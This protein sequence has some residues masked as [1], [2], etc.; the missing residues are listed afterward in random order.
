MEKKPEESN[1]VF[2]PQENETAGPEKA[3][4]GN[5]PEEG[6]AAAVEIKTAEKTP[7]TDA[8]KTIITQ[9]KEDKKTTEKPADEKPEGKTAAK[10]KKKK[11]KGKNSGPMKIVIL[12]MVIGLLALGAYRIIASLTEKEEIEADPP[13]NVYVD[14]VDYGNVEITTPLSGRIEPNEEVSLIP[15]I[16]GEVE[17]LNVEVGDYVRKGDVLFRI[18]PMQLETAYDQAVASYDLAQSS[19]DAAKT[20]YDRMKMLYEE[21]VVARAEFEAAE[22]Q[23]ESALLSLAQV[24]VSVNS[25]EESLK[26]AT[27]LAPMNGYVTAVNIVEGAL[28]TQATPAVTIA[29]TTKLKINT[30]VSEYLISKIQEGDQVEVYIKALSQEPY[31]GTITTLVR[32]PQSGGLTYPV[33][34]T[35]NKKYDGVTSGMFAEIRIVSDSRE[36]VI[37]V[38]SDTVLVKNGKTVVV[39]LDE[40]EL[41]VYRE[42]EVG[43][44]NGAEAE[45]V[46]GLEQGETLVVSGQEYIVEGEAVRVM[47]SSSQEEPEDEEDDGSEEEEAAEE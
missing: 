44:D 11:G 6:T 43:L 33:T 3:G 36:D 12:V 21:G 2:Q 35:L 17:R 29:D 39:V 1:A 19:V 25:A 13:T 37:V 42:V 45:I 46:S 32:T 40:E 24:Q 26:N 41:P 47:D 16:S 7:K 31:K 38:P 20:N 5:S 10:E 18:D 8:S 27:V 28:A 30:S 15:M 9:Q 4:Q 34:V 22:T 14:T 23:Y